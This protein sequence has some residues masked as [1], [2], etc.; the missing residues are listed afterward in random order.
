MNVYAINCGEIKITGVIDGDTLRGVIVGMPEPIR[1]VSIR[2]MQIDT[3]EIHRSKCPKE[4]DLALK[5]KSF[6]IKQLTLTT[7]IRLENLSWDKYG[8]RI[9]ADVYF[10]DKN[11]ADMLVKNQL[12][13]PYSGAKKQDW[14]L[15]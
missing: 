1:D 11:V 14:C 5:A 13:V 7:Y 10:D 4:K 12:A 15:F 2:V 3:A 8:G 6:L 9:L